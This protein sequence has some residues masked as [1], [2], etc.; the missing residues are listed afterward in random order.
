MQVQ[1]LACWLINAAI[2]SR[3][4]PCTGPY[5]SSFNIKVISN[6]VLWC[7]HTIR[8]LCVVVR[9]H[10]RFYNAYKALYPAL[11]LVRLAMDIEPQQ[12]QQ[13]QQQQNV[14]G[15]SSSAAAAAGSGGS[16]LPAIISPSILAA[17]FAN[18]AQE[19][20]SIHVSPSVHTCTWPTP[21]I[22]ELYYSAGTCHAA[23]GHSFF[24][25]HVKLLVSLPPVLT[26]CTWTCLTA[27]FAPP[28]P[29]FT[30]GLLMVTFTSNIC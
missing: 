30:M 13:Q 20:N 28:P 22:F 12:Q 16:L 4:E 7:T 5:D 19:V 15:S 23:A 9:C 11:T 17:D 27:F 24:K 3:M 8:C 10:C 29:S 18:L 6:Q 14:P 2:T 25:Q 21:S 1:V 26:G